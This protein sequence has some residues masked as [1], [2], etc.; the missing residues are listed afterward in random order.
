[1][2]RGLTEDILLAIQH[3][4][5]LEQWQ[6]GDTPSWSPRWDLTL[7]NDFPSCH[8]LHEICK[9]DGVAGDNGSSFT[10]S[11]SEGMPV[12]P[13]NFDT[14]SIDTLIVLSTTLDKIVALSDFMSFPHFIHPWFILDSFWEE[15]IR[16]AEATNGY[17]AVMEDL[18]EAAT[19]HMTSENH[20]SVFY[21]A[22]QQ[23][24][25]ISWETGPI[26]AKPGEHGILTYI[27]QS[28]L[29]TSDIASAQ[30]PS[31]LNKA[32]EAYGYLKRFFITRQ[33]YIGVCPAAARSGDHVALLKNTG[34]PMI[35]RS[36]DDFY[37]IV[38]SSYVAGL[39]RK[40][41]EGVPHPLDDLLLGKL[42]PEM[43]Q[44]R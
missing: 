21:A 11:I 2:Q 20:V 4:S 7:F 36:Q 26:Y 3:G 33:G 5:Q 38:G 25:K 22:R 14:L 19:Y 8:R 42:Q 39:D 23:L 6:P 12:L 29:K 32:K 43:I 13:S 44:I 28:L 17:K 1:V 41:V 31:I 18:C 10:G 40:K 9:F 27:V 37:R 24:A 15:H 16:P 30:D 34:C 35:L